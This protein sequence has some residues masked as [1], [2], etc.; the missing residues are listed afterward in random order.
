M[1]GIW[2][3]PPTPLPP[4]QPVI[5]PVGKPFWMDLMPAAIAGLFT[6]LAALLSRG[7]K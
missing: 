7:N 4:P 3:F 2:P 1:F 6:L 5:V